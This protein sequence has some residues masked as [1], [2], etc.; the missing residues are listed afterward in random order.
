LAA[1]EAPLA[2]G[3]AGLDGIRFGVKIV[4]YQSFAGALFYNFCSRSSTYSRWLFR[5]FPTGWRWLQVF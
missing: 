1:V 4:S 2:E 5:L 3:G